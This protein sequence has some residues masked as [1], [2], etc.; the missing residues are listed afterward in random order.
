MAKEI[1]K[2][3]VIVLN[4]K[5]SGENFIHLTLLSL[6]RGMVHAMQ[7]KSKRRDSLSP[8]DLYDEADC[9]LEKTD[10]N[11]LSFLKDYEL[12]KRRTKI[13]THY[14]SLEIAA[15]ISFFLQSNPIHELNNHS[16]YS[17]SNT[18]L[19]SLISHPTNAI[20][21]LIKV[22][23]RYSRDEGFPVKEDWYSTLPTDDSRWAKTIIN[24]PLAEI[25][26]DT[27][28][29][30]CVLESLEIYLDRFTEISLD[31]R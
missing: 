9:N 2:A 20:C 16:V 1:Y 27:T 22:L 3:R 25:K 26:I 11:D 13:G 19:D 23:Y 14:R 7:R 15:R 6:D 29:Q 12:I 17:L 31:S 24:T 21:I 4:K 8:L 18:S 30:T 5:L 28:C 10:G